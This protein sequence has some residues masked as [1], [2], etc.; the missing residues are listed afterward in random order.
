MNKVFFCCLLLLAQV[1]FAQTSVGSS[2]ASP[3]APAIKFPPLDKSPMDVA[4][5]PAN[6]PVL[7]VQDKLTE[8]LVARVI[9]SRPQKEGR[10]IFGELVEY[11]KVW[12]FG[13]NEATELEVYRDVKVKDKKLPKGRYSV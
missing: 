3:A 8:P 5:Y 13:A 4:Y 2:P 12:R 1:A 9:Y 7:K 11:G 6:Y 10:T